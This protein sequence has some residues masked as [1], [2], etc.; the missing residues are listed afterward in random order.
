MVTGK[1]IK[2]LR[3]S[4]GWTQEELGNKVGVNRAA[5]N[6]WE[7]GRVQNIKRS[8]IAKLAEVFDVDP[9]VLLGYANGQGATQDQYT[10]EELELIEVYR[11]LNDEGKAFIEHIQDLLRSSPHYYTAA[12][13]NDKVVEKEK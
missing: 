8:T 1:K 6:K 5:V 4:K 13:T 9:I 10:A 11:S 2:E 7:T 3:T 12:V